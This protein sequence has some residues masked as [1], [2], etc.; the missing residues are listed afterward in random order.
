MH[1]FVSDR[2]KMLINILYVMIN[3][4]VM[5]NRSF[6][7]YGTICFLLLISNIV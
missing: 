3:R 2:A 7:I 1:F 5:I 4:N 6:W